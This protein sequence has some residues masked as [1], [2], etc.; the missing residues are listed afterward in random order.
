M[1]SPRWAAWSRSFT[2]ITR[3]CSQRMISLNWL[4]SITLWRIVLILPSRLIHR[5]PLRAHLRTGRVSIQKRCCATHAPTRFSIQ[6]ILDWPAV[7]MS[8]HAS[9]D[10]MR[11]DTAP[12]HW[13]YVLAI[14]KSQVLLRPSRSEPSKARSTRKKLT[15]LFMHGT[16]RKEVSYG[17]VNRRNL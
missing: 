11:L 9:P 16:R 2:F 13:G 4:H 8:G 15:H 1:V 17:N 12:Q 7:S 10:G 6:P 5:S 3:R 14:A